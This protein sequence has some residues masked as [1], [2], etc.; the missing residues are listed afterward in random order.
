MGKGPVFFAG[1]GVGELFPIEGDF[2]QRRVG[3][4]GGSQS[5]GTV[6]E[7]VEED[8]VAMELAKEGLGG[9]GGGGGTVGA[10]GAMEAG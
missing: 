2:L 10:R 4:G 3:V 7:G 6:G 9:G 5:M 1:A 8:G